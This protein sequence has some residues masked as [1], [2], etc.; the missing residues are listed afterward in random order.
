MVTAGPVTNSKV[1]VTAG[2]PPGGV[3]VTAKVSLFAAFVL[4]V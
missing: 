2:P 3:K 4:A 1:V